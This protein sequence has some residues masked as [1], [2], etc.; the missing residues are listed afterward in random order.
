MSFAIAGAEA[1]EGG[2]VAFIVTR[3]GAEGNVASVKIKTAAATSDGAKPAATDDYT[4]IT[5]ARTLNFAKGVTS[6]TVEVQTTQDDLFEPDETFLASLSAPALAE[7]DPGTGISIAT[8]K[9]TAT[10][11]I[12]NDDIQPSFAVAD[13]SAAEGE[14]MTFTV[15]PFRGQGQCGIGEVEHQGSHR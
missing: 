2:K 11:T 7:G 9:G 10:G 5:T 12:K 13:A 14:A 15:N 1:T 8:D 3:S 4:A 6:H